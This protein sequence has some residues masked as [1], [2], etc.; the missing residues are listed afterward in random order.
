VNTVSNAF[1]EAPEKNVNTSVLGTVLDD[2]WF[3][4]N[5]CAAVSVA[6]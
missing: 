4:T 3:W 6:F 2:V 5:C 1:R